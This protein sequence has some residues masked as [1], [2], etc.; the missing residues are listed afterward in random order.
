[1]PKQFC[2]NQGGELPPVC[3]A[4]RFDYYLANRDPIFNSVAHSADPDT[5]IDRVEAKPQPRRN[6][7]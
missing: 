1:M 4:R 7:N 3:G 5:L 2:L 6:G